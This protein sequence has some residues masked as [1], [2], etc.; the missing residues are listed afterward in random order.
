ML[1]RPGNLEVDAARTPTYYYYKMKSAD[2]RYL[3]NDILSEFN[4]LGQLEAGGRNKYRNNYINTNVSAEMKIIDGLKLKGVF[5]ADIM[6][7][8]RFTRNHAVAYYSSEEATEPRPIKKENNK[9][10]NWNSNAY[11]INTQ[12]LLDY[13]KTFGKHT[14]NGLVGLTNESYT[15]SSNEIEKKY[16]DPDLGIDPCRTCRSGTFPGRD[17]LQR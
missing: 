14:V 7:D 16:V 12:L 17:L 2:G 5:G 4:P 10:S 1:H 6:N 13:N 9:T 15:Q 11:L 3:L 8:T